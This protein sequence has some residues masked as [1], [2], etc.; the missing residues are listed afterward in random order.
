LFKVSDG[1]ADPTKDVQN[2]DWYYLAANNQWVL[3]NEDSLVDETNNFTKT[4]IITF[5]FPADA[6]DLNSL[7]GETLFWIRGIVAKDTLACCS[8]IQIDAQAAKAVFSDYYNIGNYYKG[9]L[10]QQTISK[11]VISNSAIKKITQPYTSFDG[12][13][14]ETDSTFYNRVSERLR[15][16]QRAIT[17]WDYERIVLEKFQQLYKVKCINHSEVRMNEI[18]AIDNELAPGHVLIVPVPSLNNKNAVDPLKPQTDL[19]TLVEIEHYLRQY[20]SPHVTIQVKNAKFEEIQLDF[21]VKFLGDDTAYY[22]DVL[23]SEIEQYLSPWAYDAATDIEFGGRI[24]KSVLINFIE[25]RSYVDYITCF[26]MFH[27]VDGIKSVDVE[28]AIATTSRTVF[29][30][31]AGNVALNDPKHNIDYINIDCDC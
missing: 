20:T 1:S 15:H 13:L 24:T 12:K 25:E 19:G 29:V 22:H 16:K 9:I 28:D 4:G 21:R 27:I 30:S 6:T 5:P 7:M 17:I 26:K 10:P 14:L 11:M 8:L 18:P 23:L 31:Y 2:I 3:F